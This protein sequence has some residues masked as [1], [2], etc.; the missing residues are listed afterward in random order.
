MRDDND[1]ERA[2]ASHGDTVWR[3]C[4]MRTE[5]RADA[6]DAFQETFYAYA[7]HDTVVFRDEEHRRAWLIRVATNRCIDMARA[8]RDVESYEESAAE[9]DRQ[10][11]TRPEDQPEAALWEV[12]EALDRLAPAQRQALYLTVC[13]GYPAV[14]A[15]KM[16]GVPVNTVY[17]WVARGKEHLREALS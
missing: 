4:L 12:S 10:R 6:Q 7:T 3:V 13:E 17:S 14:E 11:H 15:A 1:I 5:S 8:C 9:I 16:M 2:M